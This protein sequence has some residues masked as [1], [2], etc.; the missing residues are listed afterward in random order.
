M[1][2]LLKISRSLLLISL[3]PGCANVAETGRSQLLL[4]SPEQEITMGL[5]AFDTL[6]K[7][8]PIS[9]DPNKNSQ[10]N[11]V[12]KRI[13]AVAPLENA[14][15]EFVLFDQP[16]T[17]N[18]FCL[19]GGKIGVFTGI[20]P[21]AQDEAGLA[22]VLAHEVAHAVARHGAERVSRGMMVQLGGSVLEQVVGGT[23][24]VTQSLILG[25]YGIGG[26]VGLVLPHSRQQELEA[27]HLGLLYMARAGYDPRAAIDFWRRFQAY[28]EKQGQGQAPAEF[29]STHPLDSTRIE[30]L[31]Q[32]LP[33]ALQ[34]YRTP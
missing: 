15:W 8:T 11:R 13:A 22:T 18:A 9:N 19:P 21:I 5:Q 20:F 16:D 12:G 14:Q 27:D 17:P 28:S 10:L 32:I 31:Q 2:S 26:Q 34:E 1:T 3:L 29:L 25:A 30:Q 6:K 33:K 4:I 7:E 24:Q 23:S